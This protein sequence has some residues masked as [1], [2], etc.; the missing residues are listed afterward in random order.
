MGERPSEYARDDNDWYVEPEWCVEA[1]KA[2]VPLIG[3]VHDPCCGMGTIPRV[4]GGTGAD[5]VDRGYGYP[6]RDFLED[7]AAYDNIVTNPPYGI[8]QQII[9]HALKIAKWRV[10]A[11]VQVKFLA[12]QRRHGLFTR[13]ETEKVLMFSR[14]PSMPPGEMLRESGES[15][16]GG[17]SIDFCWVVWCRGNL[18]PTVLDWVR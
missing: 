4:M 17:G 6:Q 13:D 14:R 12:S 9:E 11:L 15:I 3:G 18:A 16:R 2:R 8:A 1:L 7:F 10:A 5:L